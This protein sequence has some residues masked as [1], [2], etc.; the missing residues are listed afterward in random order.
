MIHRVLNQILLMLGKNDYKIDKE[1]NTFALLKIIFFK[2]IQ[3]IR[4]I[5]L[6]FL[7]NKAKGIIFLGKKVNIKFKNKLTLGK[8]AFIG[9]YVEIK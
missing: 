8:T 2:S 7:I 6:Y 5:P 9:D 3:F 1:I 4:S